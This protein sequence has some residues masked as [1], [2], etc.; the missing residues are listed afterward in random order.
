MNLS[1][2]CQYGLRAL[3]ELAKRHGQGPVRVSQIAEAQ[4]IPPRFLELILNE[5]RHAGYVESRRG[6]QGGYML[7]TAP[8]ALSVGEIIRF[9]D[10]PLA[11]VK[12]LAAPGTGE[13]PLEGHCSFI[14][15]WERATAAV[16][17]VYDSTTL[18]DLINEERSVTRVM[19]YCI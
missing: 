12:C 10:G 3:F 5:L 4:A 13:C 7:V 1:Q 8:I 15:L 17:E 9:I 2:K 6:V 16:T 18:Q 11:P 19:N 14:G